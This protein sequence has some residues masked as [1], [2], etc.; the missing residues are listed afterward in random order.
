MYKR[1]LALGGLIGLMASTAVMGVTAQGNPA[2]IP[3]PQ[4]GG[5]GKARREHHPEMMRAIKALERA[6]KDLMAAAHDYQGHRTKALDLTRQ[7]IA[8]IEA[9][10]KSDRK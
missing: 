6:Q 7:A 3:T 5:I 2:P 9:G 8:E 1:V 4:G 10:I